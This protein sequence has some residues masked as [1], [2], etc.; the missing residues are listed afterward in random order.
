MSIAPAIAKRARVLLY[1]L[2]GHGRSEQPPSGYTIDDM[3]DDLR[4]LV[5]AEAADQPVVVVGH[6]FGGHVA[7]RFAL[8]HRDR[9]AALILLEAHSGV[10]EFGAQMAQ[11]L[12]L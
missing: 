11:T 1:D 7:L 9:T 5:D 3:V 6:S 2:R 8:R 4:G 10:A 12:A